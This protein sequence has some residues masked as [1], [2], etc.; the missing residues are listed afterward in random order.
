MPSRRT[1]ESFR[2]NE[3]AFS[4]RP[5]INVYVCINAMKTHRLSIIAPANGE[6]ERNVLLFN[7]ASLALAGR[8]QTK[9]RNFFGLCVKSKGKRSGLVRLARSGSKDRLK[10]RVV[11][12][13]LTGE[14][15]IVVAVSLIMSVKNMQY[16]EY[17]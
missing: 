1:A 4:K 3:L 14:R 6:G 8:V 16:L 13:V 9:A 10:N 5:R 12:T 11:D 17:H 2:L 15:W 7:N